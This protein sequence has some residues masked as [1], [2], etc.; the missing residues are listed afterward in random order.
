M[1]KTR[2][3]KILALL[4][5]CATV[6]FTVA[7]VAGC[8][9]S[10]AKITLN[11]ETLDLYVNGKDNTVRATLDP[12][13]GTATYEW[14]ISDD[15][16]VAIKPSQSI[17]KVS[18]L[19]EGT[20][21]LT[22][23]AG[24]AT[25]SCKITVGPDQHVKLTAPSFM[26]DEST[27]IITIS[28]PNTTGVGSYKLNFYTADSDEIVGSVVVKNGEVVDTSRI[29]MGTYTVRLVAV[30]SS[31][32]Y[33]DSAPSTTTAT[34]TINKA[35]RYDLGT[36]DAAALEK[37]NN[38]AYYKFDWVLVDPDQAYWYDDTVH[39][40]FS[41]NVGT[42]DYTWITQLIYNY[43]QGE[44]G[45]LYKMVLSINT[46]MAGRVTLG[47]K[48]VTLDEGD[49]LV[50][51]AIDG[52][53]LFKIMFGVS[54]ESTTM[55]EATITLSIVG[56]IVETELM[57][58]AAPQ[59]FTYDETTNTITIKDEVN[60]KYD[61][62]YTLGF[63][64]SATAESPKGTTT[65]VNGGEVDM[66]SVGTGTYYLRMMSA[67]TGK[68]YTSSGWTEVMGT[69]GVVNNKVPI[70]N[71]GQG[72][73][74]KNPNKWYEWHSTSAQGMP[75][76]TVDEAYLDD[77]GNLYVNFS[78]ASTYFQPLKLHYNDSAINQGD[79]YT[80]TCK[81]YSEVEGYITV[82][83]QI[84]HITAGDN[85]ISVTRAQPDKNNGGGMRTTITIQFGAQLGDDNGG[86]VMAAGS[87]VISEIKLEK[88]DV[89]QLETPSF[90]YDS[91]SGKVSVDDPNSEEKVSGYEIG[92]FDS[93]DA[94][95]PIAYV[96]IAADWTFDTSAIVSGNYYLRIRVV[97]A[98]VIYGTSEWSAV[99]GTLDLR[100][101]R[102]DIESG[103]IAKALENQN[104]WYYYNGGATVGEDGI[105]IDENNDIHVN[106]TPTSNTDQ[107]IK[108]MCFK[109]DINQDD[110][111]ELSFVL[112]SPMAGNIT[113]NGKVVAINEGENEISVT[114]AQPNKSG[115][116]SSRP[117]ITIQFGAKINGVNENV[118]GSFLIK[119]ILVT[120]VDAPVQET[121]PTANYEAIL[122]SDGKHD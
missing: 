98:D 49:N 52:D 102:V 116:D 82:N 12:A 93:Q 59:S 118:Q 21:T 11:Y 40:T 70:S 94:A 10:D 87:F 111:Y 74:A 58:L 44:S 121:E 114:R 50:T 32:L 41:N 7:I 112:V 42:K 22:V 33:I 81:I 5:V 73:S 77:E 96:T 13:D 35:A 1:K 3:A 39:F 17:C 122:V 72:E 117:T 106:F 84:I 63:F 15:T 36:G 90:T 27:G 107:P 92:F 89:T 75:N 37:A 23:T 62:N 47:G 86:D 120:P 16:V 29:D 97:P 108:L 34:I 9:K 18:P 119:N 101:P 78:C 57:P 25:A 91:D 103:G 67:T 6:M 83:G 28:D 45:K 19:K 56:E 14:A 26:Y 46:T 64:E 69:I 61:V 4:F 68:P 100:T 80:F 53:S 24:K 66:T 99:G 79:V 30:G 88:V 38:W 51:V 65:V 105:Y 85:N 20:A 110:W 54:G 104:T 2:I 115:S 109:P 8:N 43:G 71:G 48:T 113:V 95:T 55:T 76:T 31:E 60:S